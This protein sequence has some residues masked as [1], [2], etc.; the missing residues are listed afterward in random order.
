MSDAHDSLN[1]QEIAA[2]LRAIADEI[3]EHGSSLRGYVHLGNE[4]NIETLVSMEDVR[5]VPNGGRMAIMQLRWV[6]ERL[7]DRLISYQIDAIS[8]GA[9][10]EVPAE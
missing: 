6:D 3:A 1:P 2:G 4:V 9:R 7:R 10:G 8:E 5:E